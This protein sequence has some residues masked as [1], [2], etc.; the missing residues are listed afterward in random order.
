MQAGQ[1]QCYRFY[2]HDLEIGNGFIMISSMTS[3]P[4]P[5]NI[6]VKVCE[7]VCYSFTQKLTLVK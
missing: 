3:S 7:D 1:A 4:N 5:T 2:S 6:D